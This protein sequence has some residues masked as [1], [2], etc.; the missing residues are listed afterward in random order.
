MPFPRTVGK[1]LTRAAIETEAQD[2]LLEKEANELLLHAVGVCS[3]RDR[4]QPS[5]ACCMVV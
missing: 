1:E 5:T 4:A 2:R 3:P